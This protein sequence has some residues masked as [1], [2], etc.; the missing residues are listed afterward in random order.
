MRCKWLRLTKL[1][2]DQLEGEETCWR[3]CK[4]SVTTPSKCNLHSPWHVLLLKG[5]TLPNGVW[6]NSCTPL[7]WEDL[8]SR[9]LLIRSLPC[10]SGRG[11]G[12]RDSWL[13]PIAHAPDVTFLRSW[14][15]YDSAL[16]P[17]G[18]SGKFNWS[19]L[20]GMLLAGTVSAG[21]WAGIGMALA[22]S[23]R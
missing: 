9:K 22:R 18:R 4:R 15:V 17:H 6:Q 21:F 10:G 5:L 13:F 12:M 8:M 11:S 16:A 14:L 3:V 23:W 19:F 1:L 7:R 20:I 2:L